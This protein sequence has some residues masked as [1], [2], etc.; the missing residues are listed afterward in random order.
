MNSIKS[1][2]LAYYVW[3]LKSFS[4]EWCTICSNIS[5][6]EIQHIKM[7]ANKNGVKSLISKYTSINIQKFKCVKG[8]FTDQYY[9]YEV[10]NI[11]YSIQGVKPL[12]K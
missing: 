8:Y 4:K 6:T 10:K 2:I 7:I 12:Y 1:P 3:K 11:V 5:K 9:N